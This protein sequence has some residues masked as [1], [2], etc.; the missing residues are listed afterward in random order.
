MDNPENLTNA[1][2]GKPDYP[3]RRVAITF[4]SNSAS[5]AAYSRVMRGR[6]LRHPPPHGPHDSSG[7]QQAS[8]RRLDASRPALSVYVSARRTGERARSVSAPCHDTSAR[9]PQVRSSRMCL[10]RASENPTSLP[11]QS[12][13]TSI[14]VVSC[15]PRLARQGPRVALPG[16]AL[17]WPM[18]R[19]STQDDHAMRAPSKPR[20]YQWYIP[21][22]RVSGS[23]FHT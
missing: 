22:L 21:K 19:R 13:A 3:T 16:L 20:P 9:T 18:L 11:T 17:Q 1:A 7:Q 12:A 2:N 14:T 6:V 23:R 10:T 4:L 5:H 8:S 15:T